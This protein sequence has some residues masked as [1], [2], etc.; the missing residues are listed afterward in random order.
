MWTADGNKNIRKDFRNGRDINKLYR[1]HLDD[2]PN[3]K[4]PLIDNPDLQYRLKPTNKGTD[5]RTN[6]QLITI[7]HNSTK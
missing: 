2:E 6:K 5:E 3:A 4:T 7:V 1:K